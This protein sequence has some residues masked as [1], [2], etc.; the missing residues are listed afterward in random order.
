[1]PFTLAHPAAVL[2]LRRLG[3][4]LALPPLVAG[5]MAPD[6]PYFLPLPGSLRGW[7]HSLGGAFTIDIVLAVGLLLFGLFVAVPVAALLPARWAVLARSWTASAWPRSATGLL[8]WYAALVAGALTHVVWDAFTHPDGWVVQRWSFLRREVTGLPVE[9]WLQYVFSGLGMAVVA[10]GLWRAA[11]RVSAA[12]TGSQ[13]AARRVLLVGAIVG[14]GVVGGVLKV[15]T[16]QH[17]GNLRFD[18][19]TGVGAG[20]AVGLLVYATAVQGRRLVAA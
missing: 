3:V 9:Q 11:G 5:S 14:A 8:S 18:L 2:P 1:M 15:A 19:A 12:P 10:Y 20:L 17:D 4:A 13:S 16:D 6:L 7:T